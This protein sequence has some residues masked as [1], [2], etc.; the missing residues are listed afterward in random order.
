MVLKKK[1]SSKDILFI[2]A[3]SE[4]EKGK[5]Q[6]RLTEENIEKIIRVYHE[7]KNVPKYAHLAS[8][9]EIRNND[10]NLSIPRYIDTSEEEEVIDLDEIKKLLD[11]DKKEIAELE[12]K[13]A[14]D[15]KQL[16]VEFL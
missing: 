4:F 10:Y 7:R 3:S 16:G 1:R 12:A 11:Q 9:E 13:I 6:N 15:F 14:E 2:D 5:N 8:I